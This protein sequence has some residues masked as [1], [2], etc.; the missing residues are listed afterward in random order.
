MVWARASVRVHRDA[1]T[2]AHARAQGSPGATHAEHRV[3]HTP[4]LTRTHPFP[5]PP[6]PPA[7]RFPPVAHT[8]AL[9]PRF[10]EHTHTVAHTGRAH[11]VSDAAGTSK[12]PIKINQATV[13]C[14]I[15]YIYIYIYIYSMSMGEE[16]ERGGRRGCADVYANRRD[17]TQ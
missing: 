13:T 16:S 8:H 14:R 3:T 15:I 5:P 1:Q 17:D 9:H 6:P 12:T 10:A 7:P 4:S 2:H 11:L